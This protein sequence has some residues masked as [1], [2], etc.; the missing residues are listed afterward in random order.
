MNDSNH[1][2]LNMHVWRCQIKGSESVSK[3]ILLMPGPRSIVR[4]YPFPLD[5]RSDRRMGAFWNSLCFPFWRRTRTQSTRIRAGWHFGYHASSRS[6]VWTCSRLARWVDQCTGSQRMPQGLPS[7]CPTS[8]QHLKESLFEMQLIKQTTS[9]PSYFLFCAECSLG[10]R[11]QL[12]FAVRAALRPARGRYRW[13]R[14]TWRACRRSGKTWSPTLSSSCQVR[15]RCKWGLLFENG[16]TV[17]L[18][19]T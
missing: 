13:P 2:L 6:C 15:G 14:P 11:S 3:L 12:R 8:V 4:S 17:C 1:I 16:S 19:S 10:N 7:S 9:M 18:L 5:S